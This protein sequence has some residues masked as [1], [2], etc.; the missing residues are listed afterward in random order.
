MV[1]WGG[2]GRRSRLPAARAGGRHGEGRNSVWQAK[3]GLRVN[4]LDISSVAVQKAG[5]LVRAP[6]VEVDYRVCDWDAGKGRRGP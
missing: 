1:G 4:A 2:W 6:D 5:S 3:L